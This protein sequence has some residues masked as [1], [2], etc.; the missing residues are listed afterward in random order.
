MTGNSVRDFRMIRAWHSGVVWATLPALVALATFHRL[1][2]EPRRWAIPVA[3]VLSLSVSWWM[4]SITIPPGTPGFETQS[5]RMLEEQARLVGAVGHDWPGLMARAASDEFLWGHRG[6]WHLFSTLWRVGSARMEIPGHVDHRFSLYVGPWAP[7]AVT[8]YVAAVATA[9]FRRCPRSLAGLLL[10]FPAVLTLH[11]SQD[12]IAH[13]RYLAM[14]APAVVA[15]LAALAGLTGDW[16]AHRDPSRARRRGAVRRQVPLTVV[17]M[18]TGFLGIG[19]IFGGV[20]TPLGL[21]AAWR[22]HVMP[23]TEPDHT[24]QVAAGA[25]VPSEVREAACIDALREDHARGLPFGSRL[26]DWGVPPSP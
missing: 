2:G 3:A 10:A 9:V 13:P 14:A 25:R 20:P 26:M 18:V 15:G 17:P 1:S 8:A 6:G 5:L 11:S 4:A 12:G 24:V 22:G 21:Q 23:D 16:L 19:L 7:V